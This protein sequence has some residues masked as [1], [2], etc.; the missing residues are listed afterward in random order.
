MSVLESRTE[1][2]QAS[3]RSAGL[4]SDPT[5]QS[6]GAYWCHDCEERVLDLDVAGDETPE[7]PGC[8][9]EMTVERSVDAT[10]CAC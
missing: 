10:G 9:D 6:D 2:L 1:V 8:G 7:C 3:T 4:G 5:R